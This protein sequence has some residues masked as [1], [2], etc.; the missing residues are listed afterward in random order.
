[1]SVRMRKVALDA[2][3]RAKMAKSRK[4]AAEG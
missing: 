4:T 1:V 2:T 3:T